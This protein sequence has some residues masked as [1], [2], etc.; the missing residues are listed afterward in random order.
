MALQRRESGAGASGAARPAGED[1]D[2]GAAGPGAGAGAGPGAGE[3][4]S[5]WLHAFYDPVAGLK[6]A[7][8]QCVLLADLGAKQDTNLIVADSSRRLKVWQGLQ[9][10]ADLKLLD[11][12]TAICSF[13][14]DAVTPRIP[15]IAVAAGAFIYIYRNLKPYYKF[16]MPVREVHIKEET[17]WRR[18]I[19][20]EV[21]GDA[22][23]RELFRLRDDEGVRVSYTTT[24]VLGMRSR[25]KRQQALGRLREVPRPYQMFAVATCLISI[26]KT[27]EGDDYA[28]SV[29]IVGCEGGTVLIMDGSGT[30]IQ[31]SID[32]PST[33]VMM[34]VSGV[35][36]VEYRITFSGRNGKMCVRA[37]RR[38]QGRGRPPRGRE[39]G[40]GI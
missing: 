40:H 13:Y 39:G 19:K 17:A 5:M 27:V 8:S 21:D 28:Q 9:L 34:T 26:N 38:P 33:P 32:V 3:E 20:G 10:F 23:V 11:A 31:R 24:D 12:P 2:A 7:G 14:P 15:S 16:T 30:A 29:L 1:G 35:L 25:E 18:F 4:E 36:E 37:P 22:L 6:V